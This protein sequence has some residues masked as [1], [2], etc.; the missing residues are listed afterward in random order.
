MKRLI[1]SMAAAA[2]ASLAAAI[3]VPV[4]ATTPTVAPTAAI[5]QALGDT[6]FDNQTINDNLEFACW[7]SWK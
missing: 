6:A 3:A 4:G 5:R 7:F 2:L 1:V